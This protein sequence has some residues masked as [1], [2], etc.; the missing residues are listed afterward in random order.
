M[1]SATVYEDRD[2]TFT[3]TVKKN[4]VVLTENEFNAITKFEIKV[5]G[6]YYNSADTPAGFVKTASA[7]QVKIKPKA[8]GLAAATAPEVVEFIVYDGGEYSNGVVWARFRLMISG[9]AA[10]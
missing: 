1:E 3:I 10:I 4:G 2:N 5:A 8:L 7:A 9:A 6:S